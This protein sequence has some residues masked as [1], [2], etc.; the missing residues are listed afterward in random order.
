M[1]F[2]GP[3]RP[4]QLTTAQRDALVS[5]PP[6]GVI[7]NT[8]LGQYQ[9]RISGAWRNI[10]P[11][12][13]GSD[14]L[15]IRKN[16]AAT[17]GYDLAPLTRPVFPSVISLGHSWTQL[18]GEPSS[19]GGIEENFSHKLAGWCGISEGEV[20]LWGSSGARSCSIED[21][22]TLNQG[23]GMLVRHHVPAHAESRVPSTSRSSSKAS[24]T[25]HTLLYLLNDLTA[26]TT[27]VGETGN[28]LYIIQAA[29][30]GYRTMISK[31]REARLWDSENAA[32]AY[33]QGS[34]ATN[35]WGP[36]NSGARSYFPSAGTYHSSNVNGNV[37]TFT[38]PSWL[39]P[40]T[41]AFVFQGN[42]NGTT[43]LTSATATTVTVANNGNFFSGGVIYVP[44]T[45][46][47]V[48][49][50]Y[51]SKTGST[52]FNLDAAGQAA[53][54]GKTVVA[55]AL[56]T[57]GGPLCQLTATGAGNSATLTVDDTSLFPSSGTILVPLIGGKYVIV[58]YTG[59]TG[60]T[61]TGCTGGSGTLMPAGIIQMNSGA[62]VTVG[63][64]A[65][66]ASGARAM[67]GQGAWGATAHVVVRIPV[68]GADAG[69]TIS[70]TISGVISERV[71]MGGAWLED[72][73]P[74]TVC[75]PTFPRFPYNAYL[76]APGSSM[77]A[78]NTALVNL[79]TYE[80]DSAVKTPDLDARWQSLFGATFVADPGAAG[81]SP[82]TVDI[83]PTDVANCMIAAGSQLRTAATTEEMTVLSVDKT[84]ASFSGDTTKWRLSCTRQ[85]SEISGFNGTNASHAIGSSVWD[86]RGIG[87]DRVH[88]SEFGHQV[89]AGVIFD[90]LNATVQTSIQQAGGIMARP[91]R[92]VG[93]LT[94]V[95]PLFAGGTL[96][97]GSAASAQDVIHAMPVEITDELIILTLNM[98]LKTNA[99]AGGVVQM[100][101]YADGAGQ[102]GQLIYDSGDTSGITS[103]ASKRITTA[104]INL[105]LRP[106]WV[107]FVYALHGDA[108]NAARFR[109]IA[110]GAGILNHPL[111]TQFL[112]DDN[113]TPPNAIIFPATTTGAGQGLPTSGAPT[114][115]LGGSSSVSAAT[116][117]IWAAVT[118][119]V[120]D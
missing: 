54:S 117:Y 76:L 12:P 95:G 68:T 108:T 105:K 90:S 98:Y 13:D 47:A 38:L 91:K 3:F 85:S 92:R 115:Y 28:L 72:E 89:I 45:V 64:T 30:N 77:T 18:A 51:S 106:Q 6:G 23:S 73:D 22:A 110:S 2:L 26:P 19:A 103:G 53:L 42:G 46:G 118:V 57:K 48:A 7:F 114:Q 87:S 58:T 41:L 24:K 70:F 80:F 20:R 116:P 75:A 56:V 74:P 67:G 81:A 50:T 97:T 14:G 84:G 60:T 9:A 102:P 15:F 49:C 44:T 43:T 79:A 36:N 21:Q 69:K 17:S 111:A 59:K 55:G 71:V 94:W 16:S 99:A 104:P 109:G 107:W 119:P 83:A 88:P 82:G 66:N 112:P 4:V 32:W 100:G 37:A 10:G 113:Y 33:T 1:D 39:R 52:V 62:I 35:G 29:M 8:T 61:F 40:G 11:L 5:P 78:M 120:R 65:A 96:A 93:D 63:G 25:L 27:S 86:A 101:I 34:G 31:A